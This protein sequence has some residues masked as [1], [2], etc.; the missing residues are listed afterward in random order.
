[1]TGKR[2][3]G[4]IVG[5]L[6]SLAVIFFFIV[7]QI[8]QGSNPLL[9]S[10]IGSLFIMVTTIY[11]AHGVSQQTTIAII[12]TFVSL[13]ITIVISILFVD[14]IKL[15]GTGSE[16]I[17]SLVQGFKGTINFQGLLL[18]GIIIGTLGCKGF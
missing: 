16:D 8:M 5:M 12:S 1:M 3:I 15:S 6:M 11:L 14:L 4:S 13:I 18:G 10:I 2:G 17:Y 7:P 9:I